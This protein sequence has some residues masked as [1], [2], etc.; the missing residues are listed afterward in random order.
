MLAAFIS[1]DDDFANHR[2]FKT[3]HNRLLL[4][5]EVELTELEK[6]LHERDKKD[7][8]NP[9]FRHRLRKEIHKEGMDTT[10]TEFLNL[11]RVKL[12][13]YGEQ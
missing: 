2:R 5:R 12:L 10:K 7:E 1:S 3:L 13:E 6:E 11:L 8:E 4:H 9:A